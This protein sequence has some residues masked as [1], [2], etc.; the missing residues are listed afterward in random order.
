MHMKALLWLV[1]ALAALA[2]LSCPL[3]TSGPTTYE[4]IVIDTYNVLYGAPDTDLIL[5]NESGTELVRDEPVGTEPGRLD[6]EELAIT[7][8]SGT[9]YIRVYDKDDTYVGPYAIRALSLSMGEELPG[10]L[11]PG[12]ANNP[13]S[14]EPDDNEDP[15]N[16]PTD[17]VDL[18]LGNDNY[19][20]RYLD[21]GT[22]SD[23]LVLV[24]P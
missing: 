2:L 3:G 11:D 18:P 7:L 16:V 5:Y 14:Y 20:N 17:P 8:E 24:L 10:A 4:R 21:P 1:M 15:A 13:D 12:S 23:W 22:E 6:T 19:R 9:Y